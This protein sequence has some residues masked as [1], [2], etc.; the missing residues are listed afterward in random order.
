[1]SL[2]SSSSSLIVNMEINCPKPV[3]RNQL[4]TFHAKKFIVPDEFSYFHVKEPKVTKRKMNRGTDVKGTDELENNNEVIVNDCAAAEKTKKGPSYLGVLVLE[5]KKCLYDNRKTGVLPELLNLVERRRVVKSWMKTATGLKYQQLDIQQ[6]ALRLTAYRNHVWMPRVSSSRFYAKPLAELIT[7][8]GRE[9]L[10]SSVN[11]VQTIWVIYGD[12]G[13]IMVY[14]GLDDISKAK[15]TAGK[16]IQE[17][18]QEVIERK[19]VD[20][21]RRDWSLLSKDL[22]DYCLSQILSGGVQE[23]MRN[24]QIAFKE[25]VIVRTLT[26]APEAYPDAK[27]QS[28]V[29]LRLK[30]KG[31]VIGCSAGDR[32]PYIICCEGI[33]SGSSSGIAQRAR[34]PDELTKGNITWMIDIDYY[35]AHQIHPVVSRLC[36][37]IEGTS[38]TRLADCLVL[39]SF[40]FQS[41]SAEVVVNELDTS[42]LSGLDADER[43]LDCPTTVIILI[44]SSF[45]EKSTDMQDGVSTSNFWCK[46]CCPQCP[47][48]NDSARLSPALI[49]NQVKRQADGFISSGRP[50][51]IVFIKYEW[52]V[53][54]AAFLLCLIVVFSTSFS[55]YLIEVRGCYIISAFLIHQQI[56]TI[57][58]ITAF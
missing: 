52:K 32:V 36:A 2:T 54:L 48:E 24:G 31:Y 25:Y 56:L 34:H 35:L 21:V 37:S 47:E 58:N 49:A 55:F 57:Q 41:K 23:E 19:G 50:K 46:L 38:P 53:L 33:D 6:Q 16:V 42:L 40:K 7:L 15:Q 8:Q 39:D 44:S 14:T 1:M 29:A 9:I 13:S 18:E 28:H 17:C 4:H 11:P 43:T 30:E 26:K 10:Q 12:T 20:M 51:K 27:N 22:G 3:V 5:P 45:N